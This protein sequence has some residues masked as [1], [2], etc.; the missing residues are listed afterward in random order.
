MAVEFVIAA[1]AFLLLLLL[2]AAGGDWVSSAG[3]VGAA[4][5][6]AA[7]AASLARDQTTAGTDATTAA[8]YDLSGLCAGTDPPP[9]VTPLGSDGLP[10]ADFATAT[11]VQ[12]TVRCT[13]RLQAFNVIGL[14]MS[15]TFTRTAVAP[16]DPFMRRS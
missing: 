8:D 6:D 16:L 12:V 2:V 13:V 3:Q 14:P 7:R 1:P 11:D 5:S 10:T 4:V 9:Q 15:A